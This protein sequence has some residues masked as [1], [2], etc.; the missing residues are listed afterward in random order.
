[1]DPACIREV[2]NQAA[3]YRNRVRGWVIFK[4]SQRNIDMSIYPIETPGLYLYLCDL[5]T[6]YLPQII[7]PPPSFIAPLLLW[8]ADLC[9]APP[10][11]D[12]VP[13]PHMSR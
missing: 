5:G 6:S 12:T 1:M 11:P 9:S 8:A 10:F 4:S 13:F 3:K 2:L 7:M